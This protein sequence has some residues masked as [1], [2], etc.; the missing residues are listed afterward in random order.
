[1]LFDNETTYGWKIEGE[2]NVQNGWMVLGGSKATTATCTTAFSTSFA[3]LAFDYDTK[4]SS[5]KKPR[6]SVAEKN[7]KQAVEIG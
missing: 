3:K 6:V 5:S 7:A 4:L 2:A 1:M